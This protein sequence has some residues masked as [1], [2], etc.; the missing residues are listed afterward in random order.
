[1]NIFIRGNR[2]EPY[3]PRDSVYIENGA[4]V[5]GRDYYEDELADDIA[6]G[7]ISPWNKHEKNKKL[8][9]ISKLFNE[10]RNGGKI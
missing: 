9:A 1:M 5:N 4:D 10:T 3:Y 7:M 6:I 8:F 2:N